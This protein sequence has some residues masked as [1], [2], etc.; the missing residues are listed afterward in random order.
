LWVGSARHSV[1]TEEPLPLALGRPACAWRRL[2]CER[3]DSVGRRYRL[4]YSSSN[5]G[6]VGAAVLAGLAVSV[7]P[8]SGL[9]PGMRVLAGNDGFPELP[10]CR[11]GLVRN[12]HETSALADALAEHIIS[13]LD[14]LSD[15]QA[16]AE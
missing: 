3:L 13:S 16:A 15:A 5:V 14:N 6:A 7:L 1:H 9:R 8:E 4:L 11:I 10:S 12:A 2:A